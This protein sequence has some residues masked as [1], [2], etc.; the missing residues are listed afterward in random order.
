MFSKR[1]DAI[2]MRRAQAL[3]VLTTVKNR[4]KSAKEDLADAETHEIRR[5]IASFE[6]QA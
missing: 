2:I 3:S 5:L 6:A 4:A 1:T